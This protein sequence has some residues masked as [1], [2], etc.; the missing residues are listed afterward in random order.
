VSWQVN[1][2]FLSNSSWK[3]SVRLQFQLHSSQEYMALMGAHHE[4]HKKK[5]GFDCCGEARKQQHRALSY[6]LFLKSPTLL[7]AGP[8]LAKTLC[9]CDPKV[10]LQPLPTL[11]ARPQRSRPGKNLNQGRPTA[12]CIQIKMIHIHTEGSLRFHSL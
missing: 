11:Y 1:L 3:G 8:R 5:R 10:P 6:L 4:N 2:C 7:H 12:Q 9:S